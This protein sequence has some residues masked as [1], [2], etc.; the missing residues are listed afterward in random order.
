[1]TNKIEPLRFGDATPQVLLARVMERKPRAVLTVEL[2]EK[3]RAWTS[4]SGGSIAETAYMLF[5][6]QHEFAHAW[7]AKK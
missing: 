7:D 3:N 1:M 5:V 6:A 2:D 4:W